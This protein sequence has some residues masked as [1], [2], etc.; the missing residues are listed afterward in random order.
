MA[1]PKKS[2]ADLDAELAALEAELAAL[3]G[4]RKAPAKA[5][6]PPPPPPKKMEAESAERAESS[7]AHS[8]PSVSAPPIA[9]KEKKR[10]GLKLPAR[11]EKPEPKPAAPALPPPPPSRSPS[12]SSSSSSS[13]PDTSSLASYWRRE[14]DA[15]VR[16]VP[17]SGR[18][19]RRVLDESGNVV[20]EEPADRRELDRDERVKAERGAGKLFGR[21]R[22]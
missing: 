1:K 16:T 5:T 7:S 17:G 19:I 18:A 4:K 6:F 3:E 15:W 14:G 22:A 9:P 2:A 20:R 12:P 21:F 13:I 11:K 10:F 8:A